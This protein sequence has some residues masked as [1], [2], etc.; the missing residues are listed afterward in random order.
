MPTLHSAPSE[1]RNRLFIPL[2]AIIPAKKMSFRC[3]NKNTRCF[4]GIPLFLHSVYYAVQEGFVPVVSTD[5]EAIAEGCEREGIPWVYENVDESMMENC[6]FQVLERIE[7]RMFAVLQPTS[8][9]RK[10][11]MLD[12]MRKDFERGLGESFL[13]VQRMKMIGFLN[14]IFHREYRTQESRNFFL[15]SDG[16]IYFST[17]KYF[18]E[19]GSFL[20]D[21]S[22]SVDNE[23]PCSLQ[24]DTEMEFDAMHHL[25]SL[26]GIRQFIAA[27]AYLPHCMRKH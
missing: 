8:P 19:T 15:F 25:C 5:D 16:N 4:D 12:R 9:F 6:V 24:I 2:L 22:I 7:C 14:G 27:P 10:K 11:G 18:R 23:F 20:G 26:D 21:Q 1:E 13:T 17:E 3:Q